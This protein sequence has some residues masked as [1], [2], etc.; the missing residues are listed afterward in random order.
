M[1][2]QVIRYDVNPLDPFDPETDR[3]TADRWRRE[4][5]RQ[6]AIEANAV[7]AAARARVAAAKSPALPEVVR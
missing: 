1:Q 7:S 4:Y 3:Q 5:E 2:G 6:E